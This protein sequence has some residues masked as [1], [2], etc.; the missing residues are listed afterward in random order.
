MQ[1][2]TVTGQDIDQPP[3]S[4][5]SAEINATLVSNS[6]HGAQPR[7][8][9]LIPEHRKKRKETNLPPLGP[10]F[11]RPL[12]VAADPVSS[13]LRE[14]FV[15][16]CVLTVNWLITSIRQPPILNEPHFPVQI[17]LSGILQKV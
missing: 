11:P 15:T 2:H 4:A 13:Y 10:E 7:H 8:M 1:Q 12:I 3:P 5:P 14:C 6:G 17:F 16:R 9:A